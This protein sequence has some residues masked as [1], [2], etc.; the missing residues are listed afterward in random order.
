MQSAQSIG[1]KSA[2]GM[3]VDGRVS[4]IMSSEMHSTARF[5]KRDGAIDASSP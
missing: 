4:R 1:A 3:V 2:L 5:G